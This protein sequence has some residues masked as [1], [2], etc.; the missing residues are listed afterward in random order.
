M[1]KPSESPMHPLRASLAAALLLGLPQL[2]LGVS[3]PD[4]PATPIAVQAQADPNIL[5]TLDDSGSMTWAFVPDNPTVTID[6]TTYNDTCPSG[7]GRGT[8][9]TDWDTFTCK[10]VL[11][12]GFNPIAYN[13]FV[14]YDPPYHP[15][16]TG[17]K[18]SSSFTSAPIN[19]FNPGGV[20][21][22]LSSSYQPMV[23]YSPAYNALTEASN[24]LT[25]LRNSPTDA[26]YYYAY[27]EDL[28]PGLTVPA[29][30]TDPGTFVRNTTPPNAT[31]A[32]LAAAVRRN[33]DECFVKVTVDSTHQQNFANWYSFYRNRNLLTVSAANIAFFDLNPS[34]RVSFQSLSS[35]WCGSGFDRTDCKGWDSTSVANRIRPLSNATHRSGFYSWMSRLPASGSTPLRSG[36]IRAGEFLKT[37]GVNSPRAFDPGVSETPISTC[38]ANFSVVMTDGIWNSDSP[39]AYGNADSSSVTLPDG[40]SYSPVGPFQDGNSNSLADIAFY[41]WSRDLQTGVSNDMIPYYVSGSTDYWD[42]R[43]DPATWQHMVTFTVG[44]GLG[45]WLSATNRPEWAGSMYLGDYSNLAGGTLAWPSTA[46]DSSGNVAD[47]WHAA[48]NSRGMFFNADSP[49]SIQRAFTAILNRIKANETSLGQIGSSTTRVSSDT[50]IVDSK[51]IPGEWYSTLTAYKVNEDGTR[52][53]ELWNTDSTFTSDSGRNIFTHVNG[54]GTAFDTSFFSSFGTARLGTAD[55]NLFGWLRGDR[56]K[57]GTASGSITLRKRTQL[58]GDVVGSDII[59]SGRDDEGYQFIGDTGSTDYSG[60]RSTYAA[61]VL[62]KKPIVFV[63]ANDGMLHAFDG[64]N[65]RE[66]FAYVPAA[67]HSRLRHLA[68]DDYVH[69]YYVD[70]AL[71]LRDVYLGG[72]W[73]TVLVGGLGGGGRGWFGLDVTNVI[74]GSAF[75]ASDVIFDLSF[76]A[77]DS[78]L[79]ELGFSLTAPVVGRTIT[80]QWIAMLGNGYGDN[81]APYLGNSCRAQLLIYNF[82]TN[83]LS[84]LDTGYGS[85]AAGAYNGLSSPAGL[86]FSSGAIVGAYAGDYR[87]NLWRFLLDP[88]S[89][90]WGAAE[91]FFVA[92]D[93]SG[94]RQPITAAPTLRKHPGGGVMVLFGTGKFFE[95]NDRSDKSVQSVYGLRDTGATI[96]GRSSLVQQNITS[97]LDMD[98]ATRVVSDNNVDWITK[99]GWYLD[100]NSTLSSNPSGER[101]VAAAALNFDIALFNTYAPGAN[102]CTGAG[103]GYLMAFNAFTG[104]IEPSVPLFDINNDGTINASDL[105]GGNAPSGIKLAGQSLKSPSTMLVTTPTKGSAGG[106]GST[107][108]GGNGQAPC[109]APNPPCLDGLIVVGGAC[110]P[111]KCPTGSIQV[112]SGGIP[113]CMSSESSRYPRWM[114]L[115]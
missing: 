51:F 10:R 110:A 106:G 50:V 34:Y 16:L 71:S 62:S 93:G 48:I 82:S 96:S 81:S 107:T 79:K 27:Y 59:V 109:V 90:L 75:S 39:T 68:Q 9:G 86:E 4:L 114:E 2:S 83:S 99:R 22:N 29:P 12:A 30:G 97:S 18:L 42:P 33:R 112:S 52:G 102:A 66:I 40:K 53:S 56:T 38:R 35:S 11:A 19:G 113:T 108:C 88:S 37:T 31:C 98:T 32:G 41:Y 55:G 24:R 63:G 105:V 76:N 72:N 3:W 95:A 115:N 36:L 65:G 57:E 111:I 44:L 78:T 101:V 20:K 26:A 58:L 80:G 7:W 104:G 49:Q 77:T 15:N 45:K 6:G 70:G 67:L 47:L 69:Q 25:Y 54:S 92:K 91:V 100:L 17:T 84:K 103:A 73:K 46:P 94:K 1:F 64:A 13:P 21:V 5:L 43:N 28:G 85:C 61:Y 60:A 87:G 23:T 14:V 74:K 89:G 8:G